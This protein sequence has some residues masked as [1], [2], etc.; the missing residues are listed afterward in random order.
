[1]AGGI[2]SQINGY[3][4]KNS[5]NIQKQFLIIIINNKVNQKQL[6]QLKIN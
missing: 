2:K 6:N 4:L 1:M 5:L 3:N